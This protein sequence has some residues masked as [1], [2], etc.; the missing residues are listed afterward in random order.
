M[1]PRT[2]KAAVLFAAGDLRVT[3]VQ[4][5]RLSTYAVLCRNLYGATC[6]ATDCHIIDLSINQEVRLP[7]VLGH[8]TVGRV[9]ERGA[10][11][12]HLQ[13]GDVV[14][15]TF[16]PWS[17]GIDQLH[18]KWGG[19]AEYG[20]AYDWLAMREDG[21]SEEEYGIHIR[22]QTVPEDIDV[23]VAPLLITWRE[24]HSYIH[25]MGLQAGQ[26]V[27]V[28]GSGGNGLSFINHAAAADAV[29]TAVGSPLR[30]AQAREC[31]ATRYFSYK[32][33][34]LSQKLRVGL[35]GGFDLIIDAIGDNA[36]C[37][38]AL[39]LIRDGG[40]FGIYGINGIQDISIN[41]LTPGHSFRFYNGG[42]LEGETHS[43]VIEGVRNGIYRWQSYLD[44]EH[45]WPLG[46]ISDAFAMLK[47]RTWAKAL[48]D[49]G[50]S[51]C[52]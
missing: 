1:L 23:R 9:I 10:G 38:V 6:T 30:E 27:L 15:R 41:P 39:P 12:R 16:L 21:L 44:I 7:T 31:G 2:M 46:R 51:L 4:L 47:Q 18:A 26:S 8:E 28:I 14:C 5:P 17:G 45:P 33:E 49:L 25:R 34:A 36:Q 50:G 43:Q 29:V 35:H 40:V 48:I 32:D 37:T 19:F 13:M 42:Y 3:D 20:L 22:N 52:D 11:V 24:T